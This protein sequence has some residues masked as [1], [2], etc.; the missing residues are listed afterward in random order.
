M[1]TTA[2][3]DTDA[4]ITRLVRKLAKRQKRVEK[5]T[6]KLDK[7]RAQRV[8]GRNGTSASPIITATS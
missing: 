6:R 1:T 8:D 4:Q 7:L 2:A 3:R 5:T